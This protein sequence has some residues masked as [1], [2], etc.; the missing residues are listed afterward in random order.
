MRD[1]EF[2]SASVN[3]DN[4]LR[5][6]AVA[7]LAAASLAGCAGNPAPD[8]APDRVAAEETGAEEDSLHADT[9]RAAAE[10]GGVEPEKVIEADREAEERVAGLDED[11]R[12]EFRA[13]FGNDPLG[14][15]RVPENAG[16]Y[17]IPLEMNESVEWWLDRFRTELRDRMSLYLR[18][19]GKWEGMIRPRLREAGLPE[20]LIYLALIESGMNPRAYSH[21]HAAGMWQF[22]ASTGR[23]YDL[24]ISYW[25]DERRDPVEATEAAIAHLSDLY[26][27]F[28]SW[29]LAAAAYNAG[30]GRV[31]WGINRTGS[32][33]YW[34]LVDAR[35]L[36]RETRNYVPKLIAAALI[37]RNPERY[38]FA[39]VDPDPPLE[40][41]TVTVPD[42]TSLD[43]VA[44]AAGVSERRIRELNPQFRRHVTPPGRTTEVRIPEG[45]GE[46]FRARYAQVPKDERVTWLVHTVTRGQTLTH[47]ARRY[48]TSTRAI[49]ASNDGL[50][51]RRLQ[52][53]QR[54]VV[55]RMGRHDGRSG[56]SPV[57][58][59]DGPAT[60]TVRRGDTLWAIA[61]R[62]DVSTREL[63][64]WNGLTSSRIKPGDRI[65]V[66]R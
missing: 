40:W 43:V 5:S 66:R 30:A 51:P 33:D 47:I 41:D 62:Y 63:M 21:A 44:D 8:P 49:L 29:Y 64:E 60:V 28:G 10:A 15:A 36:R 11:A 9:L 14:L 25:V 34:D 37:A 27:E 19:V 13:L 1:F 16:R 58:T 3:R 17:E 7:L 53:G 31:R 57:A 20:D 32:D 59:R 22:I 52:I 12:R 26:D 46:R 48:G 2:G 35:V 55:P 61:R 54:I 6:A 24:R 42:A 50:R 45:R 4:P 23:L 65:E 39:H 56:A 18:R 38:G